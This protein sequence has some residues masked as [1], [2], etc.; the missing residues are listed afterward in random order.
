M[1]AIRTLRFFG[2][3]EDAGRGVD[4]MNAHMALNLMMPPRF[5]ADESSVTVTLLLGSE[6]T[7]QERA[8][9]ARVLNDGDHGDAEQEP[10][11]P[12][13]AT[14]DCET[15]PG[16]GSPAPAAPEA[17]APLV[18]PYGDGPLPY[19]Q[20][21]DAANRLAPELALPAD[22][23]PPPLDKPGRLP[24]AERDY[25]HG[26]HQGIDFFCPRGH[27]TKAALDGRVV[28]AVGNYQDASASELDDLLAIARAL[29]ATPPYTLLTLY[30]NYVAVD[31]GIIDSVGH[32]VSIYA[33]LD[34]LDPAIR[35]GQQVSAGDPLGRV[36]N[37]GTTF[38]AA[39]STN[40]GL[41]LHWEL[42]ITAHQRP[43]PGR[44]PLQQRDPHSLHGALQTRRPVEERRKL[45]LPAPSKPNARASN[46][47][48]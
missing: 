42:H 4:L 32:I 30:G 40:Q 38:A 15:R 46:D 33:H 39:R 20:A 25:R 16:A 23:G 5:E 47:A 12:P 2:I 34:A 10:P 6:A 3:A 28:V 22:C 29:R 1:L 26:T 31:H 27:P 9:L 41:Q 48:T 44:G 14:A 13:C 8:W 43:L 24:N 18:K 7:P 21:L 45:A 11:Q 19:E 37:T 35:A 17:V 36:G